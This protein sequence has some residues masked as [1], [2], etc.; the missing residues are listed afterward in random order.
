MF[1]GRMPFNWVLLRTYQETITNPK[2]LPQINECG[3]KKTRDKIARL[4]TSD[5]LATMRQW[6]TTY[7]S[8]SLDVQFFCVHHICDNCSALSTNSCRPTK[9]VTYKGFKS[10]P[11]FEP[12]GLSRSSTIK[13]CGFICCH[14]IFRHWYWNY[15]K[16]LH[17]TGTLW[18]PGVDKENRG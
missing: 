17:T 4:E 13:A 7:R 16:R 2:R 14:P 12:T 11:G 5:L 15:I 18:H 3:K 9:K 6:K 1:A 8:P 10:A